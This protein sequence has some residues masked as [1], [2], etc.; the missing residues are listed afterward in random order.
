MIYSRQQIGKLSEPLF[1]EEVVPMK[2][3]MITIQ[4]KINKRLA[5]L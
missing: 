1:L 2:T 5:C 4:M 3:T